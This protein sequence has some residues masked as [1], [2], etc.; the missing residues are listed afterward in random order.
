MSKNAESY[1]CGC[2]VF[3]LTLHM[4]HPHW[5]KNS[6]QLLASYFSLKPRSTSSIMG[7]RSLITASGQL[8]P[9]LLSDSRQGYFLGTG[10]DSAFAPGRKSVVS[11]SQSS[12]CVQRIAVLQKDLLPSSVPSAFESQMSEPYPPICLQE[13]DPKS[14]KLMV[15]I[16]K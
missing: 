2:T 4:W 13:K 15:D 5:P 14:L 7:K 16:D 6:T 12:N 11:K 8:P 10:T 3:L 9:L 1:T